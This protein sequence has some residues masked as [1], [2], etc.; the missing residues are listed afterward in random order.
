M[1]DYRT[2]RENREP[3]FSRF[4]LKIM[5]LLFGLIPLLAASITMTTFASIFAR[6]SVKTALEDKLY[7]ANVQLN[8]YM[9]EQYQVFGEE[10]FN[11]EDKDYTYVDEYLE[12]TGISMTIF[13]GDTRAMT[14][15]TDS[16]GARIEGTTAS[17]TVIA[18]CL[19]GGEHYASDNVEINGERYLV[20]YLP[21]YDTDGNI[22]GMTFTGEQ[23]D[24]VQSAMMQS[25]SG[26]ILIA[27]IQ[28][29]IFFAII[30]ITAR[31]VRRPLNDI[32]DVMRD[33]AK[34]NISDPVTTKAS[35]TEFQQMIACLDFL[36]VNLER[37]VGSVRGEADSLQGG[38][39][40]V[41]QLS[42]DSSDSAGQISQAVEDLANGAQ[43]MAENVQDLNMEVLD[44]GEK[45]DE[46]NAN[47]EALVENARSMASVNSEAKDSMDGVLRSSDQTTNAVNNIH[48]QIIVTNDSIAKINQAI[49]LIISIA[50]QT[51]LLSLNASIEAARAGEAGKGF[52]VVADSISELSE[53]S[54]ESANT[55]REI[56]E[57]ILDN[58]NESVQ[59]A[60]R[61]KD[62]I[63]GEQEAVRTTQ[64]KFDELQEAIDK[65]VEGI[66]AIESTTADLNQIKQGLTSNVTDLSAISEENAASN[67]E[68]AASVTNI[69]SSVDEI[70][71]KM[72]DMNDMSD[73]L[74]DTVGFFK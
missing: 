11:A 15:I 54:N 23:Y 30:V 40:E 66:H 3:T 60:G 46:I 63:E 50:G 57:E 73:N 71:N 17:D 68:V 33:M 58:S 48:D 45:V 20:D 59:L 39:V 52:A 44:M 9:E 37:I 22:V 29:V 2:A 55:I 5:L 38:V 10:W 31:I 62:V 36:Q 69:V 34:G 70:A 67:E 32:S 16:S 21:L 19:E 14:S 18:A 49:D 25:I 35:V 7:S 8:N 26:L 42:G 65:S 56:A 43:S 41:E 24:S 6:N 74:E 64:E 1:A 27:V 51:K 12:T 28:A 72:K 47:L 13:M 61:I 4:S 53:Q